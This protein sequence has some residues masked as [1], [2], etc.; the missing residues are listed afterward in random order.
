[1]RT[2]VLAASTL[3]LLALGACSKSDTDPRPE[4]SKVA[5]AMPDTNAP[6]EPNRTMTA[7]DA[8]STG[9]LE[10]T[11]PQGGVGNAAGSTTPNP[12]AGQSTQ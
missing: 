4:G 12:Q 2:A 7:P 11:P 8:G 6:R 10:P 3:A 9:S 5:A 1:M